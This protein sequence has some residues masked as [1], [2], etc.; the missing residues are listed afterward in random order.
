MCTLLNISSLAVDSMKLN[1]ATA[2]SPIDFYKHIFA[3]DAFI[4]PDGKRAI[5][6]MWLVCWPGGV[7]Q[8]TPAVETVTVTVD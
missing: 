2:Q 6:L 7:G 1:M 5:C 4:Q 8:V 3:S